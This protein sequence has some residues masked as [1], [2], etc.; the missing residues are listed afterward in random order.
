M[1]IRELRETR[2]MAFVRCL[3]RCYLVGACYNTRGLQNIGLVYAMQPGLEAIHKDPVALKQARKRYLKFFNTHLFW[4]PCLVGVFLN[5][6]LMVHEGK[7]PPSVL[8]KVKETTSYTL[9]AIGDSVFSGSLLIFWSLATICLLLTQAHTIAFV[10]GFGM[11]AA[12]QL[13]RFYT[14]WRGL[15]DGLAF[16]Q[17]LRKWD[18]I[19]T[20]QRIKY[21]NGVQLVL[22]W[23]IIWPEPIQWYEWLLGCVVMGAM[24]YIVRR[25]A[26]P[27]GVALGVGLFSMLIWLKFLPGFLS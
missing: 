10:F 9:S 16:L 18:L 26:L 25:L 7:A 21:I 24:A 1:G 4:V 2:A 12:L 11:F 23:Y 8:E 13:F 19:N 6:E 22:L 3:F 20:G 15:K 17:T 5:M 27:R 14:F